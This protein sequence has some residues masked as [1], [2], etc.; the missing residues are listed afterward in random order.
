[1]SGPHEADRSGEQCD[2]A[3]S[4]NDQPHDHQDGITAEVE[5]A[6]GADAVKA[7]SVAQSE[8][9]DRADEFM[10]PEVFHQ[11]ILAQEAAW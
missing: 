11:R 2:Y 10:E 9:D 1:L 7:R 5:Q 4:T 8:Y 6:S 3:D